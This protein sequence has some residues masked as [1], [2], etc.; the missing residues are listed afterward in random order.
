MKTSIAFLFVASVG[1]LGACKKGPNGSPGG[2]GGG[3]GGWLVGASG[4]M[5]NVNDHGDLG[6]G[7][8][9]GATENLNKIACRFSGEAWVVGDAGTLLYT[10]DAGASWSAQTV[11]TGANLRALA[12]QDTGPVFVAGDG[13]FLTSSDTGAHWT[14]IATTSHFRSLAAAQEG[15]TV[16]AV[17]DDGAVFGFANGQLTQLASISGAKAVAV[18]PD[19]QTALVAGNG[20][21]ISTDAGHTWKAIAVDAQLEDVNVLDDFGDAAAVGADGAIV[22]MNSGV[23]QVQHVGTATLRTLHIADYGDEDA[24]GF[25]A[26]DGGEVLVTHDGGANW[27]FGPNVGRMVLGVDQIGAGHR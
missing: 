1:T 5:A 19:G 8:S 13:V 24:I 9:L 21:S 7:Y 3:G 18:S 11:P 14:S 4:L 2:G 26:G 6:A 23:V 12:T 25:A 22:W 16:L 20:L 17:S 27:A 10:S 15:D